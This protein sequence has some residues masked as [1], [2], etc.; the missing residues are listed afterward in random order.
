MVVS[1]T[2]S[3]TNDDTGS[4]CCVTVSTTITTVTQLMTD[5]TTDDATKYCTGMAM[6]G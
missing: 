4:R 6:T 1:V 3:G 2:S 5:H